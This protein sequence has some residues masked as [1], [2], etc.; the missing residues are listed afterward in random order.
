MRYAGTILLL[1]LLAAC[2]S[3]E[4]VSQGLPPTP[5]TVKTM[6]FRLRSDTAERLKRAETEAI[7]T[8]IVEN[9]QSWNYP[10]QASISANKA[11]TH[12][13]ETWVSQ[14]ERKKLPPGFTLTIGGED[15]RAPERQKTDVVTVGCSLLPTQ[16]NA[17]KVSLSGEFAA[18]DSGPSLFSSSTTTDKT[19][20]YVDRIGSVCL[21]LLSELKVAQEKKTQTTVQ[22]PVWMPDMRIEIKT[23]EGK[24]KPG[25][26]APVD[27]AVKATEK[28]VS[29]TSVIPKASESAIKT[30]ERVNES[31]QHKQLIIH[32]KG[33]PII[34]EFG[35]DENRGMKW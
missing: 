24:A 12:I 29:P 17:G 16:G 4:P 1:L 27:T 2:A 33:T 31:E 18:E 10:V 3:T 6:V 34:L 11:T 30:E 21:N 32:N 9:L 15:Q 7:T 13:L 23:K 28:P 26:S 5:D 20:F 19:H 8:K 14:P 25:I 35:Y 22:T